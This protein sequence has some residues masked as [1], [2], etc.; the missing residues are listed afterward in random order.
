M[1]VLFI[2][3]VNTK[4]SAE[5]WCAHGSHWYWLMY[6]PGHGLVL[7]FFTTAFFPLHFLPPFFGVGLLHFLLLICM[8]PPHLFEHFVHLLHLLQSP[9]TTI[10]WK[11]EIPCFDCCPFSDA[12]V[13][14]S[15]HFLF[16]FHEIISKPSMPLL[17]FFVFLR[18]FL[19]IIHFSFNENPQKLD[20][21]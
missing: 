7:H 1:W 4:M 8:P 11:L 10:G 17:C 15:L 14:I 5:G 3:S 16:K 12:A 19:F 6:W 2:F 9:F 20:Q 18:C 21:H 13:Y